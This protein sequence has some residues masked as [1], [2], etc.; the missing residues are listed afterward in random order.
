[1]SGHTKEHYARR[2]RAAVSCFQSV[3][4]KLG[5]KHPMTQLMGSLAWGRHH[6]ERGPSSQ[7]LKDVVY[8]AGALAGM[9]DVLVKW[10]LLNDQKAQRILID[11]WSQAMHEAQK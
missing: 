9:Y 6:F 10:G 2:E 5:E 8:T 4:K 7:G 1:M 11:A 3:A